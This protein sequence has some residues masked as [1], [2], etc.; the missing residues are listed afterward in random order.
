MTV[1]TLSGFVTEWK[2]RLFLYRIAL[3]PYRSSAL[4]QS[5]LDALDG[6]FAAARAAGVKLIILPAYNS[7][8]S[9]ADAPLSL[10]L[11]HIAQLKPVLAK[12]ADVIPF[13]KAGYIGAW[14]EW[15]GS[16]NG[17]DSSAANRKT[18]KDAILA[19][20]PSSTIVHFT[21]SSDLGDW[22]PGAPAAAAAARVGFHNDCYLANDTDA[23]QFTGLTDPARDYVK[24]MTENSGFGGETCDNVSNPEQRRLS[25]A[26][27]IAESSAYH[28]SWLNAGYAPTFLNAW[29][30]GG[31]YAQIAAFMGYRLQLD[32]ITHP[33][34]AARGS[35]VTVKLELRNVGWARVLS[36]RVPHVL[37]KVGS[38]VIDCAATT[39]LR[40]L[41]PN[42]SASS[43]I[44]ISCAI[45]ADA[46]K[47]RG[48]VF[49]NFPDA[50]STTPARESSIEP[51]NAPGAGSWDAEKAEFSTGTSFQIN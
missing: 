8:S 9:G 37:V 40:T 18:I 32:R 44:E 5:F 46:P 11:Q 36:P 28:L 51:A 10:V 2:T 45:P 27:A 21:K 31:C 33:A 1:A 14:G 13:A 43:S 6:R 47:G 25:C 42:A 38:F 22:Y 41:P 26:Q 50:W 48:D 23:H 3:D 30:S 16:S 39:P 19:G 4:P 15:W 12:N 35:S 49:V 7:D 17:L 29:K 34:A 20:T 24:A